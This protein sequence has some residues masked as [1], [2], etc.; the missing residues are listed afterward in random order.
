[1]NS[2]NSIE[3]KNVKKKFKVY[4][5]K[6]R[7]LK[8]RI[9]FRNRNHYEERWVLNGISIN[10]KKGEAVG[11]IGHNGCGKSTTLKL[12]TRIMYPDE[13][14]IEI[15]G[16]V[17]SLIE[18]GAGFHPDMSGRENIYTNASIFGLNRK[19]IDNRINDIIEFSELGK[20]LDNPVRTYSSGMYMRLAFSVAINVDAEVLLIDEIL[21]VGDANFQSKCLN[22]LREIKAKGTTIVIVS[23]SL[24]QIEQICDRCIWIKEGLIYKDNVPSE[25]V[26]QY[27]DYMGEKNR[28]FD[29]T[30]SKKEKIQDDNT[31]STPQKDTDKT[32]EVNTFNQPNDTSQDSSLD[33]IASII[34]AE[35]V[36]EDGR[37]G[38]RFKTG[39]K[40]ILQIKYSSKPELLDEPII[41]LKLYR[42]DNIISYG[43]NTQNERIKVDLKK[44]GVINLYIDKLNLIAGEYILDIAIRSQH[45]FAYDYKSHAIKFTIYNSIYEEGIIHLDHEWKF[46]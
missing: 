35:L 2:E 20:Y 34:Q 28:N 41:G 40:V 5:D 43:T 1:M 42:N 11:L 27:M 45:M 25:V 37:T 46:E 15:M 38:N 6:G 18:L 3:V 17:S 14:T 7:S 44:E 8:E 39:E 24:N 9:L 36:H 21:A 19:E 16:R 12:L 32:T 23:H 10:I 22:K 13:G 30:V 33:K 4:Y 26:Y 29:K 31:T